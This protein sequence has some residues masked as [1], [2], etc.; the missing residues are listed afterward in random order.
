MIIEHEKIHYSYDDITNLIKNN[1]QKIKQFDPDY[2]IAIG[3]GGLIPA[4]IIRNYIDRHIYVVT[5]SLYND[6]EMGDQIEVVQWV[7]LDLKDKKVLIIDEVD[8]SRKT[9]D[10]CIEELKSKNN[11]ENIGVFVL[12]NKIKNKVSELN[13]IHYMC[14][15][16][17]ED[18]WIF[19]PWDL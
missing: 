3:G 13:A 5:L 1:I 19:Y 16:T 11:A 10:F 8:D 2:V 4:R 15:E 6:T 12:Q 7:D 17:V 9:L 18:K 14:C